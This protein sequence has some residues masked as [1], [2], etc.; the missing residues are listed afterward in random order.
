L[1]LTYLNT[2]PHLEKVVLGDLRESLKELLSYVKQSGQLEKYWANIDQRN[3]LLRAAAKKEWRERK[4]I[5]LGSAFNS[6]DEAPLK[7]FEAESGSGSDYDSE[8]VNDCE[9]VQSVEEI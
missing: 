9:T 1:K 4:R 5:E 3:D 6:E 2:S 8:E 7:V